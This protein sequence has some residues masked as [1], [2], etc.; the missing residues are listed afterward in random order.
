MSRDNVQ[1]DDDEEE[2]FHIFLLMVWI[3]LQFKTQVQSKTSLYE[4]RLDKFL[5]QT[6]VK[7]G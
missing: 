6:Y 5:Y 3:F 4:H 2:N 7:N 1:D